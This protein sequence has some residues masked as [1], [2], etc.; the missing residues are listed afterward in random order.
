MMYQ[1]LKLEKGMYHITGKN[2]SEVLESVDPSA[3]YAETP[4]AGLD[5]FERQLKRFDIHV[6]GPC[7]DRVEKFFSTT[8]SAVLFP[9]FIRRAIT[10]GM[11]QSILS[12]IVA[13]HTKSESGDYLAAAMTDTAAYTVKGAQNTALPGSV[14]QEETTAIKLT[15]Y[16]R[17]IRATYEA[18]RSQRLDAFTVTL[19]SVGVRLANSILLQAVDK[20]ESDAGSIVAKAGSALTYAD[21]TKLYGAFTDFDMTMLLASPAVAASIMAM[22]QMKDMAT[23]QPSTILLPFGAQLR[24]CAGMSADYVIG[25][26]HQ[27]ALEMVTCGDLLLETDRLIDTQANCI[28]VSLR[29]G[30]RVLTKTAVHELSL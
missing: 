22:D 20:L 7:C 11:E 28:A 13:V 5:A 14:Y 21:L 19:R 1:N 30:F 15:K 3:S 17:M 25:L 16:G 12:D 4:L 24:K 23:G 10:A 27:F 18:I 9:E 6:S 2:F 26:N 29:A 8:D